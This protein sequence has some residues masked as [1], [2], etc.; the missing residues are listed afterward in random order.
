MK[1]PSHLSGIVVAT[2]ALMAALVSA[3]ILHAQYGSSG[4]QQQQSPPPSLQQPAP[5]K[6]GAQQEQKPAAQAPAPVDPEEEKTYKTFTDVKPDSFDQQIGMPVKSARHARA[7]TSPKAFVTV[8]QTEWRVICTY[9][10]QNA[11]PRSWQQAGN[12]LK[13]GRSI[14]S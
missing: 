14:T 3:P 10:Q 12:T 2:I 4:G 5:A 13:K 1:L 6:Q 8:F 9:P 7:P 11:K